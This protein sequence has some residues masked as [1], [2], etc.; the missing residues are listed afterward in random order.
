MTILLAL[1][2]TCQ[3]TLTITTTI[4]LP[5]RPVRVQV[6]YTI[7]FIEEG[8]IPGPAPAPPKP[9]PVP[10]NPSPAPPAPVP[11]GPLK[12]V[13]VFNLNQLATLPASQRDLRTNG[14]MYRQLQAQQVQW[15]AYDVSAQ[16]ISSPDWQA[17]LSKTGVPALVILDD[18]GKIYAK[19]P[20]PA[21]AAGVLA[22]V[23]TVRG[24]P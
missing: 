7:T 16:A 2:L 24:L 4:P 9:T 13:A 17:I 23:R 5:D 14:E 12:A 3:Q 1:L 6:T 19:Q 8:P 18:A 11:T 20:L 21:D 22:A 15:M 10:P